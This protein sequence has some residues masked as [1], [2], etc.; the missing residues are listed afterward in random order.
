MTSPQ[1]SC[2]QE[3]M[4]IFLEDVSNLLGRKGNDYAGEN[5]FAAFKKASEIAGISVKQ[6]I[7]NLIGI[8]VARISSLS[9]VGGGR[10]PNFESIRDSLKDLVG[11]ATL[12]ALAY[13]DEK[14]LTKE[15][16]ADEMAKIA[17]MVQH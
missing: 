17:K 9:K 8:K 13:E 7:L 3:R 14:E 4:K 15:N 1:L 12:L 5:T 10:V 2:D 11:Y 6:S 16:L